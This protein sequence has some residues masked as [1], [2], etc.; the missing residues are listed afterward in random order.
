VHGLNWRKTCGGSGTCV[1]TA[2]W[3]TAK[4]CAASNGCVEAGAWRTA[5]HADNGC[6][7][8]CQTPAGFALIRDSEDP[9]GPKIALDSVVWNNLV[10]GIKRGTFG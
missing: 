4:A 2:A 6:V 3:R 1:E 8:A 5:C 9:T 10:R 7:E